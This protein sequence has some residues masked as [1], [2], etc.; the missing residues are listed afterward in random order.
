MPAKKKKTVTLERVFLKLT[1]VSDK[2]LD[3]R[4][5]VTE[6]V[7]YLRHAMDSE[8]SRIRRTSL[9]VSMD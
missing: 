5:L 7:E 8:V 1:Q 3:H 9:R 2:L 6:G 4:P